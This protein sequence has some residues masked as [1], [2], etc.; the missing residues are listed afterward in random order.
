[1]R[2]LPGLWVVI[3]LTLREAGR[4]RAL[5]GGLVAAGFLVALSA[6]LAEYHFGDSRLRFVENV[7]TG[8]VALFGTVLAVLL[9]ATMW[10]RAEE[11]GVAA[12]LL[13]RALPRWAYLVGRLI[14]VGLVLVLFTG[15]LLLLLG[16][17]L[18][19]RRAALGIAGAGSAGELWRLGL[20]Q[21]LLFA[22]VAS[23]VT[24]LAVVVRST[25]LLL[26]LSFALVLG[27]HLVG[28]AR[29]SLPPGGGGLAWLRD[30]VFL[31]ILPDL[32][33]F[34]GGTETEELGSLFAYGFLYGLGYAALAWAAFAGRDL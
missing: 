34:R 13:S 23:M 30:T 25:P 20:S 22:V 11:N 32:Q 15:V 29:A 6:P 24:A 2:V 10:H 7:G 33:R 12:W 16:G 3:G 1:M 8:T 5:L 31:R 18:V 4:N 9:P 26:V 19:E 27:G 21:L 14:G 17:L 28:L